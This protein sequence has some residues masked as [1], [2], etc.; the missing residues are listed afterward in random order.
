MLK[1]PRPRNERM[2]RKY[3]MTILNLKSAARSI[4]PKSLGLGMIVHDK[5][6]GGSQK[7]LKW[8]ELLNTK[9]DNT[10]HTKPDQQEPKSHKKLRS[11]GI[12]DPDNEYERATLLL[13]LVA[14]GHCYAIVH[15]W[16][17]FAWFYYLIDE[18]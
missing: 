14:V 8:G 17:S 15:A 3:L 5:E 9:D 16:Y 10:S 13:L 12:H 1:T 18:F 2:K 6:R 11:Q 7:Y 4:N